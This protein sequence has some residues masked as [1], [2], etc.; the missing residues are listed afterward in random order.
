MT[1]SESQRWHRL[2]ELFDA[3]SRLPPDARVGYLDE[4]CDDDPALRREVESLLEASERGG[5][6][7]FLDEAVAGAA[8]AWAEGPTYVGRRIG[9][10]EVT[11]ELGRGGMG[12]VYLAVRA[13]DEYRKEVA[14]KLIRLGADDPE[15]RRRF[16]VERQILANLEHTS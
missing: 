5:E 1:P 6:G 15:V 16:L 12:A 10:Y 7:E 9:A 3:V 11:R 4:A 13:D 2:Q 8:R 14:V